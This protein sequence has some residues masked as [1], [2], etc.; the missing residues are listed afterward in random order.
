MDERAAQAEEGEAGGGEA[1]AGEEGQGALAPG[2]GGVAQEGA[3]GSGERS[4]EGVGGRLWARRRG[5]GD[6]PRL[7]R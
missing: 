3:E 2:E 7:A 6:V 4:E 1:E 5:T